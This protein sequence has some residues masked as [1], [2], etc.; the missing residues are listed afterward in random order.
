[1]LWDQLVGPLAASASGG[2]LSRL[3]VV[4]EVKYDN[5]PAGARRIYSEKSA[6]T[7]TVCSTEFTA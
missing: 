1:M 5:F 3:R 7:L 2:A 4:I 6:G